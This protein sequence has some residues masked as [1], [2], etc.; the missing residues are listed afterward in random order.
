MK[1]VSKLLKM[2]LLIIIALVAIVVAYFYRKYMKIVASVAHIPGPPVVPFLGNALMFVGKKPTDIV[3]M[4]EEIVRKYGFYHKILLGPKILISLAEPEDLEVILA[5]GKTIQK[6]EEYEYT[7]DW[8]GEGLIT[9]MGQKWFNRRKVITPAFHFSILQS[10]VQIFDR[11]GEIFV[12]NL[13]KHES[14]NV[15]PFTLL[16]ALDNI[17]GEIR[18]RFMDDDLADEFS[19]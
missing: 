11:N 6:S 16:C 9:S 10:F 14:V 8:I 12:D 4:G 5:Q 17:C 3:K 19:M 13:S 2:D 18:L 15:F 1:H 7:K